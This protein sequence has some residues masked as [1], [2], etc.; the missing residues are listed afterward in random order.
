[1]TFI[2]SLRLN[3]RGSTTVAVKLAEALPGATWGLSSFKSPKYPTLN[4]V[5]GA[6]DPMEAVA[7]ASKRVQNAFEL[8]GVAYPTSISLTVVEQ[9]SRTSLSP[10]TC[11]SALRRLQVHQCRKPAPIGAR[12]SRLTPCRESPA[13]ATASRCGEAARRCAW[14]QRLRRF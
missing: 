8:L 10:S 5:E 6:D 12:R 4:V 3:S 13:L 1:M 2:F 7:T 9:E 14:N 11:P